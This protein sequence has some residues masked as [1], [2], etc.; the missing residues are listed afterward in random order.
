M[1]PSLFCPH[2]SSLGITTILS[3]S[4]LAS[5]SQLNAQIDRS[6]PPSLGAPKPISL[7]PVE[8]RE[9]PNGLK[10]M[11]VERHQLPIVDFILVINAAGSAANPADRAGLADL[12]AQMLM[13]GAG[14]RT[15]LEVDDQAAFLGVKLETRSG[16]DAA[17]VSLTTPTEQMDSALA[18]M[19]DVVL[20]PT[21]PE[22]EF[23]RIKRE[24]LTA[25]LQLKDRPSAIADLAFPAILFGTQHPYGRPAP[26]NEESIDR[27]G[28]DAVKWFYNS[29]YAP[30]SATLI[31]VGDITAEELEGK[32]A[33][34]FG[35][36]ER[37]EVILPD[38]PD[39]PKPATTTIYLIDKP[40]AGQSSFRVG[41]VGV[42][43]LTPDYFPL[44]VTN[45][46]LG[47]SFTSRLNM[48]LRETKGFTYG[49]GSRF[50]MRQ[51]AGPFLARSEIV[52]DMTDS[53]LVEFIKELRAIRDTVPAE[54]LFK[55]KQFLQLQLPSTFETTRDIANRLVS[56]ALYGLPLDYYNHYSNNIATVTQQD[57]QR[58]ARRYIDPDHLVVVIVGD[59]ETVE[60][61]LKALN[62]APVEIRGLEGEKLQ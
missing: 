59:R 43:R 26:G 23:E 24:R 20:R 14:D 22:D 39:V 45:T 12:T 54:E 44:D 19:S 42:P 29:H 40:G 15:S 18:L 37:R 35:G 25:L 10:L 33:A 16:W 57:V 27:I 5:T 11:V 55:A 52:A 8:V 2:I 47:G 34:L 7:P 6:S 62:I 28:V 36:W 30:N 61:K 3:I 49:A 4:M 41:L 46:I 31:A 51:S 48:N 53:A 56:V 1:I 38:F 17:T 13:A 60:P 50:D 9:L 21:F 58:V 32:I